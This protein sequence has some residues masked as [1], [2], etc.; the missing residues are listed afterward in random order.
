MSTDLPA[1]IRALYAAVLADFLV[2]VR[3]EN[4]PGPLYEELQ[5]MLSNGRPH[6]FAFLSVCDVLGHD[7]AAIRHLVVRIRSFPAW[8]LEP[9]DEDRAFPTA[10]DYGQSRQAPSASSDGGWLR[11]M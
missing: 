2:V 5:W 9:P 1:G 6:P 11:M 8:M 7:P 4:R 10:P 3:R